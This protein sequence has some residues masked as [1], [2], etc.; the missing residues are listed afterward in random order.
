MSDDGGDDGGEGGAEEPV[1]DD[2]VQTFDG[3][4]GLCLCALRPSRCLRLC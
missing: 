3:H 4:S 1:H 2:A